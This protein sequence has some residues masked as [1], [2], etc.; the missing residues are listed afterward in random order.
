M[1]MGQILKTKTLPHG[2]VLV[3][4]ELSIPEVLQLKNHTKKVHLFSENLCLHDS[5]V[6]EKGVSKGV[7][8]VVVPL[9]LRSRKRYNFSEISYQKVES[10]SKIF[11]I[12]IAKK[13]PLNN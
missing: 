12:A 11:Y 6:V 5:T 8:T 9:S 13:D 10:D 4:L 7:K 1:S 2:K 3:H